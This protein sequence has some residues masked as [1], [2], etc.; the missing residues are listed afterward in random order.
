MLKQNHNIEEALSVYIEQINRHQ[1]FDAHETLEEIW[2]PLRKRN[3]P[4]KNLVKGL[5]NGAIC[6]EHIKRNRDE[7]KRKA[8]QVL[9]SFE[10]HKEL[11]QKEIEYFELFKEA[12]SRIEGLKKI[13]K[14]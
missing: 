11:C 2:H 7:S 13:H 3:H 9:N 6:F 12:C 10:R 14:L 5:I 4:L 8:T 1:Y